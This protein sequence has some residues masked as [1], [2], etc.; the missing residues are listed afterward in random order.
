MQK[1]CFHGIQRALCLRECC[2]QLRTKGSVPFFG[3]KCRY[4]IQLSENK[5]DGPR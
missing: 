3:G 4:L 2:P 1:Q 5:S